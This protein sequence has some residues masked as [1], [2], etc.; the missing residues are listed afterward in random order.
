MTQNE[1]NIA[2]AE[3]CG[4]KRIEPI[5]IDYMWRPGAMTR[6]T[7]SWKRPTGEP[8][9]AEWLPDFS[10]DLNA[11]HE[12]EKV[13]TFQQRFTFRSHLTMMHKD[14]EY[15]DTHVMASTAPQRCVAFLKTL[16]LW[17]D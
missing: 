8:V 2:I 3:A 15:P 17:K 16:S 13:L 4:W 10:S 9:L 11:C 14:K 12:M 6:G 7:A 1:I 5:C